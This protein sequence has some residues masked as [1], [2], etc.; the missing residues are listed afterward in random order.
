MQLMKKYPLCFSCTREFNYAYFDTT[1]GYVLLIQTSLF[2]YLS[3]GFFRDFHSDIFKRSK[4]TY[5]IGVIL[6]SFC[7]LF[8]VLLVVYCYIY[9]MATKHTI[10][11]EDLV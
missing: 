8:P 6:L 11:E 7:C 10:V 1:L 4:T 2:V 9:N 3:N 5:F